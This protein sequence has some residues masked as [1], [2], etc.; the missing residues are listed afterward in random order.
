MPPYL[1][2]HLI[3]IALLT[4]GVLRLTMHCWGGS[5]AY[6]QCGSTS[7][8]AQCGCLL[9]AGPGEGGECCWG[10]CQ[11]Q[12]TYAMSTLCAVTLLCAAPCWP[13]SQRLPLPSALHSVP[14]FALRSHSPKGP[15]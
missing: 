14:H 3:F 1:K 13:L 15:C 11:F 8:H 2:L 4:H 12:D 9:Q 7:A 6:A 10:W 5:S